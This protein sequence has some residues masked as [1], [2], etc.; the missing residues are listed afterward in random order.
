MAG[1]VGCAAEP[2]SVSS[3]DGGSVSS[4]ACAAPLLEVYPETVVA[5][6]K[7]YVSGTWFMM[8]CD[9]VIEVVDGR[10]VFDPVR[11][12]TGIDVVLRQAGAEVARTTL[13]ADVKGRFSTSFVLPSSTVA[14][15]LE[16]TAGTAE[17]G[18]VD[19]VAG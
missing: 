17:P 16:V 11:P 2:G 9:D 4:A 12:L 8:D 7:L 15:S 10:Q 18:S 3:A 1:L 14:G 19:V 13:D 5:G 6:E